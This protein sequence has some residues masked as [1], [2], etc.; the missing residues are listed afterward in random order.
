ME[1][2][3]KI[4]EIEIGGTYYT[5]ISGARVKVI[6]TRRIE[7]D[8]RS[9]YHRVTRFEIKRADNNKL[10]GK[11]RTAAALHA[12]RTAPRTT[13]TLEETLA[14]SDRAKANEASWDAAMPTADDL[15][16]DD[17]SDEE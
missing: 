11:P 3:M 13:Q 16:Q 12:L 17:E 2:Q 4:D 6:V 14:T 9:T 8:P 7:G 1:M 5:K 10:L 15:A